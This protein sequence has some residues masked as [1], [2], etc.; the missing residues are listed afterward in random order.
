M[1]QTINTLYKQLTCYVGASNFKYSKLFY[2]A[3]SLIDPE[4]RSRF[5]QVCFEYIATIGNLTLAN[6]KIVIQR[7]CCTLL[8]IDNIHCPRN[9]NWVFQY[10]I[11]HQWYKW[12]TTKP[13]WVHKHD[14]YTQL[15]CNSYI[16]MKSILTS[17]MSSNRSLTQYMQLNALKFQ[18]H[19][20]WRTCTVVSHKSTHG[21]STLQICQRGGG[22]SFECFQI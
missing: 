14:Q 11:Q 4:T 21:Q 8:D 19:R 3:L 7:L 2:N 13:S 18:S 15:C 20:M 10:T 17:F 12:G 22:C 1:I 6:H 5:T 16:C 9:F